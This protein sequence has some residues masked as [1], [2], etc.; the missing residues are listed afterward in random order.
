LRGSGPMKMWDDMVERLD[1][2]MYGDKEE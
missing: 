2:V 1:R